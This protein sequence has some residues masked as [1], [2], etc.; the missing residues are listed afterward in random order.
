MTM[1]T[2]R[3]SA[4]AR[5]A[6]GEARLI[7]GEHLESPCGGD[8]AVERQAILRD[9]ERSAGAGV[10]G[11]GWLIRRASGPRPHRLRRRFHGL[12]EE[13]GCRAR[14]V[15]LTEDRP[16]PPTTRAM[17]APRMESVQEG[18]GPGAARLERHVEGRP[19]RVLRWWR[20]APER[21][22]AVRRRSGSPRDHGPFLTSYGATRGVGTVRPRAPPTRAIWLCGGWRDRALWP[23]S[24]PNL[25]YQVL[26]A[27]SNRYQAGVI[28]APVPGFGV[29]NPV[30]GMRT[31]SAAV[32][33]PASR[34]P[35]RHPGS[36]RRHRDSRRGDTR[37]PVRWRTGDSAS[38]CA[39]CRGP[40]PGCRGHPPAIVS[41]RLVM[42][43]VNIGLRAAVRLQLRT[44][45]NHFTN[46]SV[47]SSRPTSTRAATTRR[48]SAFTE[49]LDSCLR[50]RTGARGASPSWR[51][52]GK[53]A[54]SHSTRLDFRRRPRERTR[55][56]DGRR[57]GPVFV[58]RRLWGA[59]VGLVAA[60]SSRSP[61]CVTTRRIAVHG[62]G[63]VP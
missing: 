58:A 33:A 34:R 49:L 4:S 28:S 10:L 24:Q 43:L 35:F 38:A 27:E 47:N 48:R 25:G 26:L 39:A 51:T 61:S 13:G 45:A 22:R 8:L 5:K 57:G 32:H 44:R 17:P 18:P 60:R 12:V 53:P 29:A 62:R 42:R 21:R 50:V 1:P 52:A 9:H 14:A 15:G 54:V 63:H 55:C 11:K 20:P 19:G 36:R 23:A 7:A 59:A 46:Q 6:M 2:E 16:R 41:S 40:G 3:A 30:A 56:G 31:A 37:C